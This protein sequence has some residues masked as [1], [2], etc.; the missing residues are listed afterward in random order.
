MRDTVTVTQCS[1]LTYDQDIK[2]PEMSMQECMS[3]IYE[4]INPP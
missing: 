3:P 1:G 2:I 4:A